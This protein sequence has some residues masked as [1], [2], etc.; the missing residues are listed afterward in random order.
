MKITI[1]SDSHGLYYPEIKETDLLLICG[2]IIDIYCQRDNIKSEVYL[3]NIFFKWVLKQ[4]FKKC[5]FIAGNHDFYLEKYG[6]QYG[7]Y[8]KKETNSK[9]EYLENSF[10]T[11]NNL[12][13]FGTPFCSRFFNWAFMPSYKK[14]KEI[15]NDIIKENN[16]QK[17]NIIMSHDAPY[18][19]SDI[20]EDQSDKHL[21]NKE[22]LRFIKKINPDFLFHG[23]LHTSNHNCE[24][25]NKTKIYNVSLL[26]EKYNYRYN[27][28]VIEI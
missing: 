28:L 14:Q 26:D 6:I 17:I 19:Y 18:G 10:G 11:Y 25:L 12:R 27:P 7:E 23:H 15:F 24:L 9:I 21:G 3:T 2:D 8:L 1:F 22:L 20:C 16:N 4:S 13:I 5:F